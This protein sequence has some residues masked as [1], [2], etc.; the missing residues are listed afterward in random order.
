VS[1][2]AV[3]AGLLGAGFIRIATRNRPI[4]N[5]VLAGKQTKVG[6]K[7]DQ[8]GSKGGVGRFE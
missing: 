7:F 5:P 4:A 2:Q 6:S 1:L 8:Q 3:T